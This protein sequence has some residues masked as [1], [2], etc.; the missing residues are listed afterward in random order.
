MR[1]RTET[2]VGGE[3]YPDA[4]RR[5]GRRRGKAGVRT[6]AG[7]LR[8]SALEQETAMRLEQRHI[9]MRHRR[10]GTAQVGRT[11]R[12]F[13]ERGKKLG[14]CAAERD[15]LAGGLGHRGDRGGLGGTDPLDRR[16]RHGAIRHA[17]RAIAGAAAS[18]V[19]R[20]VE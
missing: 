17:A 4:Q 6:R 14:G 13:D 12:R 8:P 2:D 18:A 20:R 16:R 5:S 15:D 19:P 9:R 7:T 10:I 11:S 3:S 1:I